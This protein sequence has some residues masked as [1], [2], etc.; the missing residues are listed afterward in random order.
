[1]QDKAQEISSV[2]WRWYKETISKDKSK[3]EW[4]VMLEAGKQLV[5]KYKDDLVNRDFA[6][7]L[8]FAF[9]DHAGVLEKAQKGGEPQ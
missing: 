7:D 6:V 3:H 1:M 2:I 5:E 9:A 8:F 4:D